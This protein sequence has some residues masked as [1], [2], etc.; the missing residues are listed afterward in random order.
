MQ[1]KRR[2]KVVKL[3]TA[4]ARQ[5]AQ[6]P[7]TKRLMLTV[8]ADLYTRLEALAIEERR[9]LKAQALVILERAVKAVQGQKQ[10]RKRRESMKRRFYGDVDE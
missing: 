3:S 10:A 4:P 9:D 1:P 5:P 8:P 7:A 6:Q 2:S